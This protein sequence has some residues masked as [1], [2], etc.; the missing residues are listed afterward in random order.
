MLSTG[1]FVTRTAREGPPAD[2]GATT[3]SHK[4]LKD[5]GGPL[6][7]PLRA[8]SPANQDVLASHR[9]IGK[10]SAIGQP[11]DQVSKLAT[12]QR[13]TYE[14]TNNQRHQ[15]LWDHLLYV[16]VSQP[17]RTWSVSA[18]KRKTKD[19]H[20]GMYLRRIRE[21]LDICRRNP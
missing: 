1:T 19:S 7:I 12:Q 14:V 2:S 11:A 4:S 13:I 8:V 10:E 18:P 16:L 17:Y 21:T 15:G 20:H 5:Y 6:L 9:V 3:G